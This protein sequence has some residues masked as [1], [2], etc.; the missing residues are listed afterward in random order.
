VREQHAHVTRRGG[1]SSSDPPRIRDDR[2]TGASR[3][4]SRARTESWPWRRGDDFRERSE[5]EQ[6][7]GRDLGRSRIVGEAAERFVGDEFSAESDASEQ[8]GKARAA[9]AFSRMPKAL[10]KR[11]SCAANCA[12]GRK[13]RILDSGSVRSRCF[14]N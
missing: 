5:I 2:V 4:S 6:A 8:A 9:M 1:A 11:S 10:R 7:R 14:V 13:N 12:P 3:S